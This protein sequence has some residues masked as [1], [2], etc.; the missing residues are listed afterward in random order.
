M[1]N[2]LMIKQISILILLITISTSLNA[3]QNMSIEHKDSLNYQVVK[4][5]QLESHLQ[6]LFIVI[7]SAEVN[8]AVLIQNIVIQVCANYDLDN[9][10]RLSFFCD[11]KYA[12]YKDNLFLG[13]QIEFAIEDY[14]KWLDHYYLGEFEFATKT[15]TSYPTYHGKGLKGK[16][17]QISRIC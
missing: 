3:Q 13:D 12:D 15:Y 9:N 1:P 16:K 4:T 8:N 10:S 11:E 14:Y 17:I 5:D 2:G 6:R 7:D